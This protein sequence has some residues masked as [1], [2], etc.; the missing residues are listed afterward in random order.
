MSTDDRTW[1]SDWAV[2]LRVWA[3]RNGQALL[4]PGRVE[5]LEGIDRWHSIS[6]AA[7]RMGMSYRH[8]WLL[9]Q[10]A[11]EAAGEPL[12][13][14]AT[15]G[16]RGGGARL[17]EQ[18]RWAVAAYRELEARLRRTAESFWPRLAR[19]ADADALHVA[20]PVSLEEVL[21]Q[22]LA[23]YA[24]REPSVRVRAVF[25]ASDELADHLLAGAPADLFVTADPGQLDRLRAHRLLTPGRPTVLAGNILA[26]IA[27]ADRLV[28]VR[29]AADLCRPDV[30]RIA[31]AAPSCP[32]GGYTR[33]YLE[34][35]GLYD[36]LARRAL[37]VDNA[38]A[39]LAAVRAG[40]ADVGLAY[41]SDA[42]S[43]IDCRILFRARRLPQPI[44]YAAAVLSIGRHPERASALVDF[45]ASPAASRRFRRCGFLS[46]PDGN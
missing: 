8:A 34:G 18:G 29:K 17:T 36:A 25:G 22:L 3:E 19:D 15:G 4:G 20:A 11:N 46:T 40:Q 37:E 38:R 5:L 10:S 35:L 32:L 27:T 31:L 6:A 12:V 9:V 2:A 16:L 42:V 1:G 7:R 43:A 39:V 44:R 41:G 30:R 21:G 45:L 28:E 26:A 24:V 23:D 14:T 13:V 33:A